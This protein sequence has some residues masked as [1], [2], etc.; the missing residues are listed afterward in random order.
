MNH[1][2]LHG[3]A[4]VAGL[5]TAEARHLARHLPPCFDPEGPYAA[6]ILANALSALRLLERGRFDVYLTR[7]PQE[8]VARSSEPHLASACFA[9][10]ALVLHRPDLVAPAL[11]VALPGGGLGF[12][13]V[14]P[15]GLPE[16]LERLGEARNLRDLK[17]FAAEDRL[18][19][20]LVRIAGLP[21]EE[22]R[23]KAA[24]LAV[25]WVKDAV[26]ADFQRIIEDFERDVEDEVRFVAG[27]SQS[28]PLLELPEHVDADLEAL[29][30]Q[31][32][33]EVFLLELLRGYMARGEARFYLLNRL[34]FLVPDFASQPGILVV[35]PL[36][37]A[38]WPRFLRKPR[39]PAGV[40]FGV[41]FRLVELEGRGYAVASEPPY[42]FEGGRD[43]ERTL[44]ELS[45]RDLGRNLTFEGMID[46]LL[47]TKSGS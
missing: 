47:D 30:G 35:A 25:K 41:P 15:P 3:A 6:R 5:E 33:G 1:E 12:S 17:R 13:G 18:Q 10:P 34:G 22:T 43:L 28:A 11:Y 24:A 27:L 36:E 39:T 37:R 7:D 2:L 21:D 40:N 46:L 42:V 9:G 38:G 44:K 32:A 8:L 16:G 23:A 29:A 45:G 19:G 31:I 26:P 20:G 4:H 14:L